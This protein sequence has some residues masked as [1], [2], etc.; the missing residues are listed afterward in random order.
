[1]KYKVIYLC[2]TLAH[3][4]FSTLYNAVSLPAAIN[5][6]YEMK[7][8]FPHFQVELSKLWYRYEYIEYC[9]YMLCIGLFLM[10]HE[11]KWIKKK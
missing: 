6:K 4:T 1:M 9:E 2:V 8:S 10:P 11:Q 3:I 5:K 7:I